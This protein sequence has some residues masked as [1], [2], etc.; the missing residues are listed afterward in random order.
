MVSGSTTKVL[1]KRMLKSRQDLIVVW[2]FPDEQGHSGVA[3]LISTL[4]LHGQPKEAQHMPVPL[5][6]LALCNA[7]P[8]VML[9]N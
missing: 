4:E 3:V 8:A 9:D 6:L 1:A 5:Y 2:F 7:T